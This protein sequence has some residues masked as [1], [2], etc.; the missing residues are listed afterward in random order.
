MSSQVEPWAGTVG[1]GKRELT[2]K[3][4][5]LQNILLKEPSHLIGRKSKFWKVWN[6]LEQENK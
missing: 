3:F 6:R 2:S 4:R 1:I 5:K